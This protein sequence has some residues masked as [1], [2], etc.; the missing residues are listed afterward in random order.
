MLCQLT[1]NWLGV[2]QERL[3]WDILD[4]QNR[5]QEAVV[6]TVDAEILS[7]LPIAC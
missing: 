2:F 3:H 7:E 6:Q 4:V 5:A 1:K